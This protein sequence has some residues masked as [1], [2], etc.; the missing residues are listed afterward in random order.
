MGGI[1]GAVLTFIVWEILI[2]F[3]V[4]VVANLEYFNEALEKRGDESVHNS[5]YAEETSRETEFGFESPAG[6]QIEAIFFETCG[7]QKMTAE[8]TGLRGVVI[9]KGEKKLRDNHFSD[10]DKSIERFQT[11]AIG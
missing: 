11:T 1:L 5:R 6:T 2:S 3:F 10:A 7:K 9:F 8:S 4:L